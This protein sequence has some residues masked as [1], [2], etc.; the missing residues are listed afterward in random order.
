MPAELKTRFGGGD[1]V[2]VEMSG[3]RTV[4][5][6]GLLGSAG[7]PLLERFGVGGGPQ[8]S[9]LVVGS[10]SLDG[11]GGVSEVLTAGFRQ[12]MASDMLSFTVWSKSIA[13]HRLL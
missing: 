13:L 12:G 4:F 2:E 7:G 10:T 3:W 6:R 5:R 8:V 9:A 11:V 1:G